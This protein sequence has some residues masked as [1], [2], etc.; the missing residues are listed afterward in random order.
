MV[1]T[2]SM[3]VIPPRATETST[4]G[5]ERKTLSGAYG[6]SPRSLGAASLFFPGRDH[7]N[8]SQQPECHF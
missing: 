7:T 3:V 6:T 5:C 4:F 2:R 8:A 1:L